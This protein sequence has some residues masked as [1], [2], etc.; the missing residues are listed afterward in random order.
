MKKNTIL[1]I[2]DEASLNNALAAAFDGPQWEIIQAYHG[3]EGL[4]HALKVKPDIIL[5]DL[6]MP[7]MSGE[8]FL[9]ELRKDDWG[10]DAKVVILTNFSLAEKNVAKTVFENN[11]VSFFVKSSTKLKKIVDHVEQVL[12]GSYE[13]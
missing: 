2:E 12:R 13:S 6:L 9:V 4:E 5:L 10:K 8:E 3:K 1:I 7:V 11:P